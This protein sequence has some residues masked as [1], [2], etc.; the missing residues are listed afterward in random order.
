M[1]GLLEKVFIQA[2]LCHP[3]EQ[4]AVARRIYALLEDEAKWDAA[5][6]QTAEILDQLA[7]AEAQLPYFDPDETVPS[8]EDLKPLR[9]KPHLPHQE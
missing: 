8:R 6:L 3:E 4:E 9:H 5:C 2:G 7:A 1:V